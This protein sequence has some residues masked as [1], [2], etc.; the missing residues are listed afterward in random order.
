MLQISNIMQ[1]KFLFGALKGVEK[2]PIVEGVTNQEELEHRS[3]Q[4]GNFLVQKVKLKKTIDKNGE[5]F[6][7]FNKNANNIRFKTA[8]NAAPKFE[9]NKA[10]GDRIKSIQGGLSGH[11]YGLKPEY[12]AIILG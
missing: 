4:L 11:P 5:T 1:S 7:R 2:V 10:K 6:N 8:S 3:L 12:I 9:E